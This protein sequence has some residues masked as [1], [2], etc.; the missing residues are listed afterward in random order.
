MHLLTKLSLSLLVVTTS[1]APRRVPAI[2]PGGDA[3]NGS[4]TPE[5]RSPES[6]EEGNFTVKLIRKEVRDDVLPKTG[7]EALARAYSKYGTTPP[8]PLL[9]AVKISKK[10]Q[11]AEMLR[12]RGNTVGVVSASPPGGQ[13]YEYVS[14]VQIGTPPQTVNLVLD[15]GSS[16]LWTFTTDTPKTQ[17][18]GHKIFNCFASRTCTIVDKLTWG[19]TYGDGSSAS[20]RV[21]TDRVALGAVAFPKQAVQSAQKVSQLFTD[22]PPSSGLMG[23][24]FA[25]SNT[26][27]PTRQVTFTENVRSALTSPLFTANLKRGVPGNYNFGY[28]NAAE[29]TGT[30]Q[31]AA[32]DQ[33]SVYWKINPSGYRIGAAPAKVMVYPSIVDTGTTL[34]LLPSKIVNEY[35]AKVPGAR[36]DRVWQAMLYPCKSVTPDFQMLIGTYAGMVPGR[37]MNYGQVNSTTCYGGI[38]NSDAIGFA[39]LGDILLKAQFVVFDMGNKRVGFANKKLVN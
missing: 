18:R 1:A 31:Y 34:L 19:I 17:V 32:V 14:P 33:K 11:K 28:I 6:P 4:V 15:T 10:F 23:L 20:G 21:Y 9:D 29:Y 3:E 26:V 16:D 8:A 7:P 36:F 35:Y 2:L 27:R 37:Y 39:I 25:N 24:A 12:K 22:D 30:I 38:Q 13:D 5:P